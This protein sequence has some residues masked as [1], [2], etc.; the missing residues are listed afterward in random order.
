M[1]TE[2]LLAGEESMTVELRAQINDRDLTSA[3]ACMA[4]G[5]G[6]ALLIGVDNAGSVVGSPPRH[7]RTN[8]PDR[9]AALIRNIT[10]PAP[11]QVSAEEIDGLPVL[12]VDVPRG[13][14]GP[15]RTKDGVSPSVS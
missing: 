15:V 5:I 6:G 12:R 14:S 3:V 8:I 4:N 13:D 9:V 2:A 7:G 1:N 11:V 10:E